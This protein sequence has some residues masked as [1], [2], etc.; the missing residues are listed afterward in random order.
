E[1][2]GWHTTDQLLSADLRQ[3]YANHCAQRRRSAKLEPLM[4]TLRRRPR[5]S[6]SSSRSA[7][8]GSGDRP[9]PEGPP[10]ISAHGGAAGGTARRVKFVQDTAPGEIIAWICWRAYGADC[11]ERN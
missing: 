8:G 2:S 5:R 6:A 11:Y 4:A 9:Q 3:L 7:E 1:G 10:H